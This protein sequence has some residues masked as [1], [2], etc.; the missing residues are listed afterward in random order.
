MDQHYADLMLKTRPI[1]I[2]RRRSAH[3]KEL[4]ECNADVLGEIDEALATE[5]KDKRI[6]YNKQLSGSKGG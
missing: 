6:A 4:E 5:L 2:G 1:L 3:K